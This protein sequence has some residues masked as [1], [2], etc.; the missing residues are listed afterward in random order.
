MT[1]E[2]VL[3]LLSVFDDTKFKFNSD[4]HLYTYDSDKFTSVTTLISKFHEPFDSDKWSKIK[5]EERGIEQ[6]EILEEWQALNDYANIVGN[7]LHDW[8]ENY[9]NGKYQKLPTCLD[10]IKRINKFNILYAQKVK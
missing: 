6:E 2:E 1:K 4:K 7:G 8:C 5:A 9:W 3:D 10:T